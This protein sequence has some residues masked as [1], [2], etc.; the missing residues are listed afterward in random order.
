M[1]VNRSETLFSQAMI[2]KQAHPHM[3][4]STCR[5]IIYLFFFLFF[6]LVFSLLSSFFLFFFFSFFLFF[7]FS[8]FL[9]LLLSF[10]FYYF[11]FFF[12][13]FEIFSFHCFHCFHFLIVSNFGKN[14]R[15]VPIVTMTIFVCDNSVFAPWC[16][17]EG[18]EGLGMAHLR[19]TPA[20]IYSFF[21][22]FFLS[23]V[24]SS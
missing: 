14:R 20:F 13:F 2:F 5:T 6:F 11:L 18:L 22:L 24:F 3:T 1:T 15:N 10:F 23:I 19:V 17:A 16:T 21:F 8:F 9:V 7:F 12:F 4:R